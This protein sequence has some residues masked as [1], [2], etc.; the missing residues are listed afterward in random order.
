MNGIVSNSTSRILSNQEGSAPLSAVVAGTCLFL[1]FILGG[2]PAISEVKIKNI[3]ASALYPAFHS[4]EIKMFDTSWTSNWKNISIPSLDKSLEVELSFQPYELPKQKKLYALKP[5]KKRNKIKSERFVFAAQRSSKI[6]P[7][8]P[9]QSLIEKRANYLSAARLRKNEFIAATYFLREPK[10]PEMIAA[11]KE[12]TIQQPKIANIQKDATP[13]HSK[14][15]ARLPKV[16][17][18]TIKEITMV[19]SSATQA[20]GLDPKIAKPKFESKPVLTKFKNEGARSN[21]LP[22][23]ESR[24]APAPKVLLSNSELKESTKAKPV[25]VSQNSEKTHQAEDIISLEAADTQQAQWAEA[26]LNEQLKKEQEFAA[27]IQTQKRTL[28]SPNRYLP[29]RATAKKLNSLPDEASSEG[30]HSGSA[31]QNAAKQEPVEAELPTTHTNNCQGLDSHKYSKPGLTPDIQFNPEQK[32]WIS[33]KMIDNCPVGWVK[34]EDPSIFP[35]ITMHSSTQQGS[36]LLLDQNAIGLLS[37]KLGVKIARGSGLIVGNIPP[38]YEVEFLG[39]AEEPTPFEHEGKK[40]FA[41]L[42]AEP[43]SGTLLLEHTKNPNENASLFFPVLS[44]TITYLDL[45]QPQK[46]TARFAVVKSG[47]ENDPE[48]SGLN[49]WYSINREIQAITSIKGY[50]ELRDFNIVPGYPYFVDL[51]SKFGE[52]QSYTYRYEI[53]PEQKSKVNRLYQTEEKSIY[54][55]LKQVRQG[56]SD[57]SGLILGF[58]NPKKLSGFKQHHFVRI[59]SLADRFNLDPVGLSISWDGRSALPNEPLEADKPR[60]MGVQVP[61]GVIRVQIESE[62]RASI[63]ERLIP[64]SPRVINVILD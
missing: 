57:Q 58:V 17:L 39:R 41:I 46:I 47:I 44:D 54:R 12:L 36:T 5:L 22:S 45:K 18:N 64:V 8:L 13:K 53:W 61:E 16:R 60:Y 30:F 29:K 28:G 25:R 32:A 1:G 23:L 6:S 20:K 52:V 26:L 63:V 7:L 24:N 19:A 27:I 33:K 48:I 21:E 40:Y 50:A 51:T 11:K 15:F 9:E 42:N 62:S 35:T 37:I 31:E 10:Q 2:S 4:K 43:G 49:L 55:W 14:A 59:Q 38:G 3:V 56:V 34:L